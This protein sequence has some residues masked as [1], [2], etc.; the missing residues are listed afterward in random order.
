MT[1]KKKQKIKVFTAFS[2]YD[3]QMMAMKRLCRMYPDQ[4]EC[5]LVGW[6]EIDEPAIRSHN[7]VFPESADKNL[8]DISKIDWTQ[9]PDFDLFTY[10]SPC[11]DFSRAGLQKGGEA[12]SGTRSSLLWECERTIREKRPK[13]CLLENVKALYSDKKFHPLLMRWKKTVDDYGY[14]SYIKV[15]NAADMDVPQGRER[16]FMVSVRNDVIE[17]VFH[18]KDYRFPADM[19]RKRKIE[20]FLLPPEQVPEE[21][22]LKAAH[23]PK[24]LNLLTHAGDDFD[25]N[26]TDAQKAAITSANV[27]LTTDQP[28]DIPQDTSVNNGLAGYVPKKSQN[29]LF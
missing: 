28:E 15:I 14:H 8:G 4:L 2:G 16:V 29:S 9:V 21:Y 24:F 22:Y 19:P 7:A 6:S 18:G 23:L 11:Q 12:G 10:S 3:S 26:L 17:E 20:D 1:K 27:A 25:N 5:E 13:F